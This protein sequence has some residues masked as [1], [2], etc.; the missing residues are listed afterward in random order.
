MNLTGFMQALLIQIAALAGINDPQL[1]VTPPGFLQMLL[2]NGAKTMVVNHESLRAGQDRTMRVRYMQRGLESEVDDVDDCGAAISPEWKESDVQRALFS[3][4]GISITDATMH[5]LQAE[6]QQNMPI[7]SGAGVQNIA[8]AAASMKVT[9]AVWETMLAKVNGLLQKSTL[10]CWQ[11]R[12][13]LGVKT[14]PTATR[15]CMPS[16]L[17]TRPK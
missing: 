3:K 5:K 11:R 17:R 8:A 7:I 10:T 9:R 1:K 6:A 16:R 4:I 13:R 14:L 12:V 2:E 15:W